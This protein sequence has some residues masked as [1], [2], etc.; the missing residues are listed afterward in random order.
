VVGL[1]KTLPRGHT[2][3]SSGEPDRL[4]PDAGLNKD[5]G[6]CL[7]AQCGILETL[8]SNLALW[9]SAGLIYWRISAL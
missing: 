4:S 5:L 2:M 7:A 9:K 8:P 6:Q 3:S 1:A